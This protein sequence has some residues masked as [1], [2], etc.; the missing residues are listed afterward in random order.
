MPILETQRLQIQNRVTIILAQAPD[1]DAAALPILETIGLGSGWA[2]GSLW[3]LDEREWNLRIQVAWCSP[4]LEAAEFLAESESLRFAPGQGLPGLTWA[5]GCPHWM[6]DL[7]TDPRF[8]RREAARKAGLRSGFAFPIRLQS[9]VLGVMAFFSR[10]H[11]T[12]DLEFL[13]M[14]DSLGSQMGQFIERRRAE[15]ER[16]RLVEILEATSDFV[17]IADPEGH[18]L[19]GNRAMRELRGPDSPELRR[20]IRKA[21]PEWAA[22]RVLEEAV[23]TAM[24]E[25]VW[26]G[27]TALLDRQ[28][29]EV[30]IS[31]VLIAHRKPSGQLAFLSTIA[32]DISDQKKS[33]QSL[34]QLLKNLED[35]RYA[36][37]VS[38]IFAITDSLGVIT[39]VNERF[40]DISGY[41]REELL[42]RTH[43]LLNSGYH[44]KGFFREMW[45]TIRA[46]KVWRG[47]IRNLAKDGSIYWVDATIVPWLNAQGRPERFISL[48]TV[49]TERKLAEEA[50]LLRERQ[51]ELLSSASREL[52]Q[53][54]DLV[55]VMRRLVETGML[56]TGAASGTYGLME[57]E[58]LHIGDY[59]KNGRW[60]P[61]DLHFEKGNSL[62]GWVISSLQS[63]LC[64]GAEREPRVLPEVRALLGFDTYAAIPILSRKGRPLGYFGM[65]N[66]SHGIFDEGD[67]A[68]LEGL[69]SH[70]AVA[71]ENARWIEARHRE[72]EALRHTQKLESLGLMA[73]G[74]AHD[75][76]NLLSA[77]LGNL[78]LAMLEAP[79]GSSLEKN[80]QNI[81]RAVM[82]AADLTRQMLAYA[83]KGR[84]QI[85]RLDLN[86]AVMEIAK[87]LE[88][89]LP[90]KIRME[91]QLNGE[92]PELEGDPAQI[93]QVILN[94]VTNA[95]DAIGDR[96]G[97]IRLAT[98][99][100]M[101]D[102]S[103][104]QKLF[105]GR[106]LIPGPY[107]ALEVTD[108][109]SGISPE[110]LDRIF[111]PFFTTKVKG[112]G[113]GLSAMLGILLG[114]GGGIKIYSELGRGSTFRVFLPACPG[115][116]AVTEA[117]DTALPWTGYGRILVV[118]DDDAVRASSQALL[119]ALGFETVQ[120]RDGVEALAVFES[121]RKEIDIVFMDLSMPRMDGMEALH[122]IR[123]LDPKARV[124]LCSGFDLGADR[125]PPGT[126]SPDA[127]IQKPFR[128]EDLK[129]MLYR[130]LK[131]NRKP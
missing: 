26:R 117:P 95:S 108:D 38:A 102:G 84:F 37:D 27:E 14:M 40:C 97:R 10:H 17:G 71:M 1:L 59:C 44:P 125:R 23:P 115:S 94:L 9:K 114:H 80:L 15:A 22:R 35:L 25:G 126:E 119:E 49:I 116:A 12:P 96:E 21:H 130:I 111:D 55:V 131:D 72:E 90:K 65:H 32:R 91:F 92:L 41:T 120:A 19:Y 20:P 85:K 112:R 63:C 54:L 31:Q 33:E 83:G 42:G 105:P 122:A 39:E 8:L 74:L 86:A 70:A 29:Q 13:E 28:G 34:K 47:E 76:N 6:E 127:F 107:L 81:D 7:V 69:A 109:G 60:E 113:L 36:V 104:L 73:G 5:Q 110:I 121:R 18:V 88:A 77:I 56:L 75:F 82:R 4:D 46:G 98:G 53:D 51:M 78:D 79:S 16:D 128:S 68:L 103:D 43:H 61:V 93:G 57:G 52:N 45:A 50:L 2:W 30:P 58:R 124:V 100:Q 3:M 129:T 123:A 87:L 24:K 99:F 62:P 89:S 66:K 11:R 101:L 106:E 64:D 67:R 118:D 48:R